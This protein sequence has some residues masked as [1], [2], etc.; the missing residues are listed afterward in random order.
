MS[1]SAAKTVRE[2]ALESPNATRVFE[3]LGIDYCC[4]GK[5]SLDEAC[6]TAH[7]P[8][9]D[10]LAA[11]EAA[12][13]PTPETNAD[14]KNLPL[15]ELIE[16][17]VQ[18]HHQYTR[19]AIARIVP[20]AAKVAGKHGQSHPELLDVRDTF[21]VLAQ[22]LTMHLM[23]EEMVLFPYVVRMEE[24]VLEGSPIL[25]GPF[26]TVR[27]P[28]GMMEE[29]HDS[30]GAALRRLRALTNDYQCPPDACVSYHALYEALEALEADLHQ[31]IHKENNI[32][33]PRA[34]AMEQR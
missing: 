24:S 31:H 3:K 34:V 17:I 10:V 9:G 7:L 22:E 5:K 2:V 29:E 19:E 21:S 33:H 30:A 20:L 27:N 16:H 23:K 14:H 6:N 18:T 26:G 28:V 25:P 11:L 15:S 4:G 12:A 13:Q 8:I 1:V 32:L